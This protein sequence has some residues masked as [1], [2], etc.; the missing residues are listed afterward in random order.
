MKHIIY[1]TLFKLP[2]SRYRLPPGGIREL[3][4]RNPE[5]INPYTISLFFIVCSFFFG[6]SLRAAWVI[7]LSWLCILVLNYFTVL[8]RCQSLFVKRSSPLTAREGDKIEIRYLLENSSILPMMD[9]SIRDTFSGCQD[10]EWEL[11]LKRKL[12][13][14]H[15][16]T[17]SHPITLNNGMG[18]KSFGK[19]EVLF[20]DFLGIFTFRVIFEVSASIDIL[21]FVSP[22]PHGW[23]QA[24]EETPH[25]GL[26]EVDKKGDSTNFVDLREYRNGDALRSVNWMASLRTD[27]IL[28]N[29]FDQMVDS[30]LTVF[31]NNDSRANSGEGANSS[32]EYSRDLALT[33]AE[34]QLV[35]G[36]M[37]RLITC[38]QIH[39]MGRGNDFFHFLEL[40][41][42]SLSLL[43]IDNRNS[44]YSSERFFDFVPSGGTLV[45][46]SPI[47]H[48]SYLQKDMQ[49][50]KELAQDNRRVIVL[51]INPYPYLFRL[52]KG[53]GRVTVAGL[54][55]GA[56]GYFSKVEELLLT[57]GIFVYQ[58][59]VDERKS[60][61]SEL[62]R[63][64][65]KH[66]LYQE[67][68]K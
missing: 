25:F 18:S 46:L 7:S 38:D 57:H 55:E 48:I 45:Y 42:S 29:E 12:K 8:F 13:G 56:K 66:L 39:H 15:S 62:A 11:H 43:S 3:L 32:F 51:F 2:F 68:F 47:H 4:A 19:T 20:R 36:N 37:L 35:K 59:E 21:P 61:K 30:H 24:K 49:V 50:L 23:E 58:V 54:L 16:R 52:V 53:Q 6:F 10:N 64:G 26:L 1:P 33:I 40:H 60:F 44:Y 31:L 65:L 67:S 41:L 28:V 9:I 22:F 27:K 5:W 17:L 63:L 34:D 14:R